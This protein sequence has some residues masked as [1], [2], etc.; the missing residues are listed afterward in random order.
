MSIHNGK[1]VKRL[2]QFST[3]EKQHTSSYA[4]THVGM[5]YIPGKLVFDSYD[6]DKKC[7]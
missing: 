1:S 7:I 5:Q 3:N 4:V 2:S 6:F